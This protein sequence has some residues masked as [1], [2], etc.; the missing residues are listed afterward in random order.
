MQSR[1]IHGALHRRS[2]AAI[3]M[4]DGQKPYTQASAGQWMPS[5]PLPPR[6]YEVGRMAQSLRVRDWSESIWLGPL[7]HLL[8][9]LHRGPYL[10]HNNVTSSRFA[11]HPQR[12]SSAVKSEF[13]V[14]ARGNSV[15]KAHLHLNA[16]VAS[17]V[18]ICDLQIF[19]QG[20]F[21][22]E[23]QIESHFLAA[24]EYSAVSST[25]AIAVL[26]TSCQADIRTHPSMK[27]SW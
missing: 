14:A 27:L 6:R 10:P 20:A 26:G 13:W 4:Q 11:T 7:E 23:C 21:G 8:F 22:G 1:L 9:F 25:P 17:S 3:Y 15:E 18:S 19:C 16:T 2:R 5:D 24:L 12:P